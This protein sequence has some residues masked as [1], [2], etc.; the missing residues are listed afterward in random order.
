MAGYGYSFDRSSFPIRDLLHGY[1]LGAVGIFSELVNIKDKNIALDLVD[2]SKS[3]LGRPGVG[4]VS[5]DIF[6][7]Y[8]H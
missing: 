8:I 7:A 2:V 3:A 4:C 6:R 1:R 5:W